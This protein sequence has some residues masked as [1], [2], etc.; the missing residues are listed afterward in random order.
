MVFF[1]KNTMKNYNELYN[2]IAHKI[3]QT[4]Y[5]THPK[6]SYQPISYMMALGG[7][8]LRP[9]L[10]LMGCQMFDEDIN[11]AID[12]AHAMEVF[13]NF[14]LVH[15]DI[16]DKADIRR[17]QETIYKKWNT[18]VA[19]LCGDLMMI[20]AM[21]LV[22]KTKSNNLNLLLNIFN[23]TA[24]QVCEGQQIDVNFENTETVTHNEYIEMISLKT[25]VLLAASLQIGALIGGA[26]SHEAELLYNF[27]KN[28]GIAFQI[29][30]DILDC[31][32]ETEKIGK[33]IGGDIILNK[34]TLLFIQLKEACKQ[35]KDDAKLLQE[36]LHENNFEYK[37]NE[38]LKLYNKYKI[39]AF[40][41]AE[42]EKY[43]NLAFCNL[44]EIKG[45]HEA[46]KIL[47]NTAQQLM[48][49]VS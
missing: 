16:M 10:V 1:A 42:K 39:K 13:H 37:T 23:K 28:I 45:K 49:R 2:I 7:K 26:E 31:F 34:K 4:S 22:C 44:N 35:H 41:Q 3:A 21:E 17:G 20:K 30:D 18:P 32:G 40:A 36:L 8:R 27:G 19:I 12:A 33:K 9:V 6:E 29:Q 46:K 11:K 38:I 5:G 14:T 24:I 43:I 15:D 25:S 47:L 48:D